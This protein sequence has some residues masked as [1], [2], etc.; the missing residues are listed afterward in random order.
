MSIVYFTQFNDGGSV[1]RFLRGIDTVIPNSIRSR[2]LSYTFGIHAAMLRRAFE[3][4]YY[5]YL[6]GGVWLLMGS[7]LPSYMMAGWSS[8]RYDGFQCFTWRSRNIGDIQISLPLTVQLFYLFNFH[9][10]HTIDEHKDFYYYQ[11]QWSLDVANISEPSIKAQ[12]SFTSLINS[13]WKFH[14]YKVRKEVFIEDVNDSW[15]LID[16][17]EILATSSFHCSW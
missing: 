14:H 9:C 10:W 3:Y 7:E 16:G 11:L 13:S 5:Q 4:Y 8:Q 1:H 6:T 15:V 17:P 12:E 2:P